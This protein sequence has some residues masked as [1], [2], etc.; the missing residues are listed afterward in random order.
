MQKFK[1]HN[2]F[3]VCGGGEVA[4]SHN[5]IVSLK[6]MLT[7][8][9]GYAKKIVVG[10][11]SSTTTAM[12][13]TVAVKDCA[14]A[15]HN[16]SSDNGRLFAVYDAVFTDE[17][18]AP[19]TVITEVA[20]SSDG[21]TLASYA[22]VD[23]A[24]KQ[25]GVPLA[26]RVELHLTTTIRYFQLV[27]GSNPLVSGILGASK[28]SFTKIKFFTGVNTHSLAPFAISESRLIPTTT[29][30]YSSSD[31][32]FSAY[33]E[34]QSIPG[35]IVAC[36]DGVPVLRGYSMGTNG[37]FTYSV[38]TD[39]ARSFVINEPR[40]VMFYAPKKSDGSTVTQYF[41]EPVFSAVTRDCPQLLRHR[42]DRSAT[43]LAAPSSSYMGVATDKEVTVYR[44]Q[45][46]ALVPVYSAQRV[47]ELVTL[48]ANGSLVMGGKRLYLVS[49]SSGLAKRTLLSLKNITALEANSEGTA[50]HIVAVADGRLVR[51]RATADG[52]EVLEERANGS[53]YCINRHD[54]YFIDFWSRSEEVYFSK[55]IAT[56]NTDAAQRLYEAIQGYASVYTFKSLSGRWAEVVM[57]DSGLTAY[58]NIDTGSFTTVSDGYERTLTPDFTVL[59]SDGKLVGIER[60]TRAAAP[61]R[62]MLITA[63]DGVKQ[64]VEVGSYIVCLTEEGS[65]ITLYGIVSGMAIVCPTVQPNT[66]LSC[67][68]TCIGRPAYADQVTKTRVRLTLSVS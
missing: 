64:A 24:V 4:C 19:G 61:T 16:F 31:G 48:T 49:L 54:A 2:R 8:E 66:A 41:T 26:V 45:S 67:Q 65:V 44:I 35:E 5:R 29:Y 6:K 60:F 17:D 39:S 12:G 1:L 7:V 40:A 52:D 55:S 58:G 56:E 38:T 3:T 28:L 27:S 42:L 50:Y 21:S 51:L 15:E 11:G 10:S 68:A 47:G 20:L 14:L 59:K 9:G 57:A 37:T 32:A 43:L 18:I 62:A 13:S 63:L 30:P 33:C 25:E 22:A 53:T 23:G 36:Y 34:V 46:N